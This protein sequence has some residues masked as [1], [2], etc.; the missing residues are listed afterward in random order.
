MTVI[1]LQSSLVG[2]SSRTHDYSDGHSFR[3]DSGACRETLFGISGSS[4]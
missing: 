3:H 4:L 2:L 1:D